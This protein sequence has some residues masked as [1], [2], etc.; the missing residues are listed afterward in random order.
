MRGR[1][2]DGLPR[3]GSHHRA[4]WNAVASGSPA[5]PT[6][7]R[8]CGHTSSRRSIRIASR[9]TGGTG[10]RS[11][12]T[13][14][15]CGIGALV[16][17]NPRLLGFL[18]RAMISSGRDLFQCLLAYT[19]AHSSQRRQ[20]ARRAEQPGRR[21]DGPVAGQGPAQAEGQQRCSRRW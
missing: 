7:G 14:G 10:R 5:V 11:P 2:E 20:H 3:H 13:S 6:K 15:R 21:V 8:G 4:R 19:Q 16:T 1:R 18:V 17:R 12:Y 9:V